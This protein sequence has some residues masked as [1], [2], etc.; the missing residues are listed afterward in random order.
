LIGR[1][2]TVSDHLGKIY[3]DAPALAGPHQCANAA[4]AVAMLRRQTRLAVSEAAINHGVRSARWPARMQRL[5]NGPVTA[6]LPHG[7]RVWLDGGHNPDAGRAIAAAL[8]NGDPVDVI[9]GMLANKDAAG[10]LAPFASKLASI[11]AVPVPGYEHHAPIALC[12]LARTQFG[13]AEAETADSIE[14][15]I[16]RIAARG[17]AA[18][19]L[20]CGSLYLAG[21]VLRANGEMPH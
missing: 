16:D 17:A 2:F 1:G 9:I 18:D 6:R 8:G 12:E 11:Q 5:G 20:I 10:F 14:Q 4:L 21:A 13:L 19:L 15:A 3:V 7:S